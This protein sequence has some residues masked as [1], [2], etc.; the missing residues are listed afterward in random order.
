MIP[1]RRWPAFA[2]WFARRA[3]VR[4]RKNFD[5]VMISGLDQARAATASGP[6]LWIANHTAWWDPMVTL[7]FADVLEIECFA[8][9]AAENLERLAFFGLAG[10]FG[11]RRGERRDGAE[12][13]AHAVALLDRPR[14]GVWI[15]PQG[16]T[17][18]ESLPLKFEPGAAAIASRAPQAS[19]IPVGLRYRLA[20]AERP[21]LW[22]ALGPPQRGMV[23]G[24]SGT[25]ALES[26]V[27][28]CLASIDTQRVAFTPLWPVPLPRYDWPTRWLA[29]FADVVSWGFGRR[30]EKSVLADGQR[31]IGP[32]H[33]ASEP[34][35][36][37]RGE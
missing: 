5:R 29:S 35:D 16:D 36:D 33:G 2:R 7:M 13:I 37:E 9:M 27:S 6:T 8:M 10:G 15:F 19:V 20:N 22:I 21:E 26:A 18:P 28:T 12:S 17:R 31:A 3:T 34:R 11:V 32:A 24:P 25:A 23:A 4:V 30:L 1:A 14:R